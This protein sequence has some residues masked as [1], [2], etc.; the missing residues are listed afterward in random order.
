MAREEFA[1]SIELDAH[2]ALSRNSMG[3]VLMQL[4]RLPEALEYYKS[5]TELGPGNAEIHFNYAV[6]LRDA[7]RISEARDQCRLAL[8][9]KPDDPTAG[10]LLLDLEA[11]N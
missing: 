8:G 11:R 1:R 4:H 9:I 5:A 10:Q 6:A 2:A 3:K 7:G